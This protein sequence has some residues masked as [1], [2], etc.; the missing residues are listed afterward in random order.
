[1]HLCAGEQR[2]VVHDQLQIHCDLSAAVDEEVVVLAAEEVLEIAVR[3]QDQIHLP[4]EF[5]FEKFIQLGYLTESFFDVPHM[6]HVPYGEREDG[7]LVAVQP[8]EPSVLHED[9]SVRILGH[10]GLQ[11]ATGPSHRM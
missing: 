9:R 1:M 4:L 8:L 3:L 7:I 10:S 5:L 11:A 6:P 2:L